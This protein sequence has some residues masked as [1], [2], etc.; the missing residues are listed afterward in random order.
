MPELTEALTTKP[1]EE[2]PQDNDSGTD[3][4]GDDSIPEL[5]VSML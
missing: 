3:S 5:E 4:D 2:T 1:E